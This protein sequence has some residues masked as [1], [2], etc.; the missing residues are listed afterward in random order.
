MKKYVLLAAAAAVTLTAAPVSAQISSTARDTIGTLLGAIFGGGVSGVGA[1][2][3][4]DAQWAAG[5]MPLTNQRYQFESRVDAEVRAGNLD[6]NTG[7]RLKSDYYALA[8]L[9]ASYGAD[10]RFT[11]QERAD[12]TSRYNGLTQVLANGGYAN[13]GY[14]NNGGLNN[15]YVNN[16]NQNGGYANDGY[17]TQD[18][19]NG[20]AEFNSRVDASLA[21]RRITR[22]QATRLKAD[23]AATVLLEARYMR[24]NA[25]S[26][27]ERD[28]LDA[29]L[30]ALDARLGDT[31]YGQPVQQTPRVRLDAVRS[32]LSYSG[33]SVAAQTQLRVEL[34]D[35]TR[36]DAAYAR[37]SETAD[38]RAYLDRRIAD[39]EA[40]ARV[41][42]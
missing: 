4:A 33:L 26:P 6:A 10:G 40:R 24:D 41:R 22:A 8:Q 42:R 23:Y 19:V 11:T 34:D 9:E 28:D 31:A 21:A 30:D 35:L 39:V 36:L 12:L 7:S 32:A 17:T 37:L 20:R 13:N 5:Q 1:G 25:I 2:N 27:A 14:A 38:E 15:G 18:V 29:R 16:S 3:S